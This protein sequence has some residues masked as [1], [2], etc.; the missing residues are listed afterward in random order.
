MATWKSLRATFPE[1]EYEEIIRIKEKYDISFNEII[2]SGV[3]FYLGLTLLKESLAT[4]DYANGIKI[5][6]RT[7]SELLQS[8]E[9]QA[10][11]EQKA[12]KLIKIVGMEILERFFEFEERVTSI[13]KERKVGRPKKPR[14][15]G[16]PSQYD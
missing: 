5:G 15:V 1:E 7:L 13:T 11:M 4:S 2:R 14:K 16:R 12:T 6:N 9:Y 8:P 3:K 10:N